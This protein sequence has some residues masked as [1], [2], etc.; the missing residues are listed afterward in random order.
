MATN[1]EKVR[2]LSRNNLYLLSISIR[3]LFTRSIYLI[4]MDTKI[5]PRKG[6]GSSQRGGLGGGTPSV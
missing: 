2:L 6:Q 1:I 3:L 4:Y 5:W